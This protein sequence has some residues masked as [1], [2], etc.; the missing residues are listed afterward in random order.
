MYNLS[1]PR[2]SSGGIVIRQYVPRVRLF[3]ESRDVQA[4]VSSSSAS[5]TRVDS[6]ES[7]NLKVSNLGKRS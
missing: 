7:D 2:R 5:S 3:P 1:L 4:P 6:A